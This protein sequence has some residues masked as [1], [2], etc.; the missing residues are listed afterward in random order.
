MRSLDVPVALL[1]ALVLAAPAAAGDVPR[2]PSQKT[3]AAL[4]VRRTLP[5]IANLLPRKGAPR[6]FAMQFK[7]AAKRV[8]DYRTFRNAIECQLQRHVVPRLAKGRP[9]VVVFPEDV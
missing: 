3:C 7:Q 4:A 5:A 2:S 1:G 6:V 8:R 9:N